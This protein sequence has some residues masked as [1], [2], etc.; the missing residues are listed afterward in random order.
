M[1]NAPLAA[2]F[3]MDGVIVPNAAYH[4]KAWYQ[5][6]ANYGVTLTEADYMA[7]MNGHVAKDALEFL[8]GRS[9][10][11]GELPIYTEEKEAVYRDLYCAKL[12]PTRGL[13]PFLDELKVRD[14]RLAVGTSAPVSNIGFTLDGLQIRPYFGIVVDASMIHRGK[15]DPQ[16][17]LKAAGLVGVPPN[18]CIVFEDAFAGIEAGIRAGMKVV[19]L[20]TTHTRDELAHTGASLI[21]DDFTQIRLDP[22]LLD[23]VNR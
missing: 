10:T 6:A 4:L 8:L 18:R 14:V 1:P 22:D 16:I 12:A 2:L 20:A 17:Y 23:L 21:I 5:F 3:D 19:A 9:L 13:I 11:A 15:P 7:H